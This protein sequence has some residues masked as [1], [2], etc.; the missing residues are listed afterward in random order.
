ML[1]PAIGEFVIP[2]L[3]GGSDTLMIGKVLWDEF[4]NK[5]DSGNL[6]F[7][8]QDRVGGRSV[9]RFHKFVDRSCVTARN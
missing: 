6:A 9:S 8:Y 7:L 2:E 5:F 1:I 4:F 3:L